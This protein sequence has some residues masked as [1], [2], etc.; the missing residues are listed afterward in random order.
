MNTPLHA[1]ATHFGIA[2]GYHDIW[3]NYH[4]TSDATFSALLQAMHLPGGHLK[5]DP[6]RLLS[7]LQQ[8]PTPTSRPADARTCYQPEELKEGHRVWGIA[9]QLY[10]VRS[11][12]NWGIGDFTDLACLLEFT[13]A[14][15]GDFVG[16]N[17]LH[18]L[19]PDNP[20]H[21][22]PYSPSHR[23]FINALYIDVEAVPEFADCDEARRRPASADFSDRLNTLRAADRV[24]YAGVAAAKNEILHLLF[25]HQGIERK[26]AFV[27]WRNA[28]GEM[29]EQLA[30]FEVLQAH[31]RQQN[32]AVWGWPLWPPAFHDPHGPAVAEFA[33]THA[34]Q[35]AYRAWLQWLADEQLSMAAERGRRAG[36]RIGIYQDLAIGAHPG[37]AENWRWQA[38]FAQGAH[39]GAPPDEINSVGQD[40]GLP[41]F[42]PDRLRDAGFAPLTEILRAN[43]R[44]A[45]A[46]R[47]DHVMGL[48]RLFWIPAG[49]KATEGTYIPYPFEEMVSTVIEES[50]RN[51]CLVIGEDLGTV[52]DGFRERMVKA[53][54]FSYHPMIFERE[55]DG[56]FRLPCDI[57]AQALVAVS[58]HDLPTLRGFWAGLDLELRE[59]LGLFPNQELA[60]RLATEREWDRGRLLW[61]L[62]RESL[63]PEGLAKDPDVMPEIWTSAVTAV[64]V[65]LARSQARLLAIQAE[66]LLGVLDQANMPGT[67]EDKHPNWQQ[68]LPVNLE[69]WA[70]HERTQSLLTAVS[71]ERPV[72]PALRRLFSA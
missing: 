33:A 59:K 41:P 68:R 50:L 2:D 38:V 51:K 17:P 14:A 70:T 10:G 22:S 19:F 20:H 15:G 36:L 29:L 35:I 34:D 21:I 23:S 28:Q 42:V 71:Q 6:A 31:F 12:R 37:G 13:A 61:A 58:T 60:R 66:D 63:L 18:T 39:T 67:L 55:P 40:W 4:P 26:Q 46:L 54:I 24:D 62:E 48:Q 30:R 9:V 49:M 43:M 7:E 27:S 69:D 32:T 16:V 64:H 45:G 72:S 47:I 56:Q 1:L 8:Q 5:N 65:F 53:G 52:P 11:R 44:H 57:T 3:G 25:Q